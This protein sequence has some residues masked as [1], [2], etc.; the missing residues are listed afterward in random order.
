MSDAIEELLQDTDAGP[1]HTAFEQI[2]ANWRSGGNFQL[3]NIGAKPDDHTGDELRNAYA[4]L[5]NNWRTAGLQFDAVAIQMDAMWILLNRLLA[6]GAALPA[7]IVRGDLDFNVSKVLGGVADRHVA[8]VDNVAALTSEHLFGYENWQYAAG[9]IDSATLNG[10]IGWDG[11]WVIR[12]DIF[13]QVVA[14]E[15]FSSYY[16]GTFTPANTGTGWNGAGVAAA[17][18]IV[19]RSFIGEANDKALRLLGTYAR[20]LDIAGEWTKLRIGLLAAM[21]PDGTNDLSGNLLVGMCSGTTHPYSAGTTT[22]FVG[23]SLANT[24]DGTLTYNAN[25]GN[26]YFSNATNYGVTKADT[27]E[28]SSVISTGAFLFPT[29]TGI[30]ARRFVVLVDLEKIY[31]QVIV[32]RHTWNVA[33]TD[34]DYLSSAML[35]GVGTV[36]PPAEF[37]GSSSVAMNVSEE[38]GTLDT[39]DIYWDHVSIP[40]DIHHILV[41]R[42]A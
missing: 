12:T 17:G 41:Y 20:T 9:V 24:S 10:G 16:T 40:I 1:L 22:N 35:L 39:L 8:T 38:P 26:P 11:T 42:I 21:T 7:D 15:T 5:N 28:V 36:P 6:G 25:S 27:T 33:E 37:S 30:T 18:T 14:E 4:K 31:G 3:V 34:S 23:C 19:T 2:D 29:N 32:T 13:Q